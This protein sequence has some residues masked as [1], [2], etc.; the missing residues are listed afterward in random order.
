V[1]AAARDVEVEDEER[2]NGLGGVEQTLRGDGAVG[3]KLHRAAG[4]LALEGAA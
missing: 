4:E 1:T 3:D 2:G